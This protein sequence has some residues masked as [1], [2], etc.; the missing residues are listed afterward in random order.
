MLS[1]EASSTFHDLYSFGI[2]VLNT[3]DTDEKVNLSFL[4]QQLYEDGKIRVRPLD[5]NEMVKV[6]PPSVPARPDNITIVHPKQL[7]KRGAGTVENRAALIHSI[8]HMESYA[9]DLSWDILCRFAILD[10]LPD[11]FLIDW[12]YVALDEC[13]H[14]K[15]LSKRLTELASFYGQFPA[16]GGLWAAAT[17]TENDVM[18]RLC[19]LHTVHEARGLDMT[20]NNIRRLREAKDFE[21]ADLLNVILEEEVSHVQK[22]VKWFK[23]CCA[24]AIREERRKNREEMQQQDSTQEEEVDE[25]LIR[26]RFHHLVRNHTATGVLRPPFNH[27]LRLKAGFTKDWYEPL[28][29]SDETNASPS[30]ATTSNDEEEVIH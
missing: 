5:P 22:G 20:P 30:L 17:A 1:M 6:R 23:F 26:Q 13:R 14:F 18:L 21:S 10:Y 15:M 12:F 8:C 25:N 29:P 2:Q 16:H 4:A 28:I 19:I 9:I 3:K 11:E 27:E 24:H 7:H